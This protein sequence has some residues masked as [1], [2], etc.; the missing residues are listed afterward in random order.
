MRP[1]NRRKAACCLDGADLDT[2]P[3]T[4]RGSVLRGIVEPKLSHGFGRTADFKIC[5]AL[6]LQVSKS[7]MLDGGGNAMLH[8]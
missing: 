6:V 8:R 4:C 5:T 3:E 1:Q 2:E 7:K